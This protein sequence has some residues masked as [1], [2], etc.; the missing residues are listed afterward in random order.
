[1]ITDYASVPSSRHPQ[2]F[3]SFTIDFKNMHQVHP[4]F[5]CSYV[6][7]YSDPYLPMVYDYFDIMRFPPD[8]RDVLNVKGHTA[9]ISAKLLDDGTGMVVTE[10]LLPSYMWQNLAEMHEG[11]P[12]PKEKKIDMLGKARDY[13]ES[14]SKERQTTI[15]FPDGIIGTTDSIGADSGSTERQTDLEL[16]SN[17]FFCPVQSMTADKDGVILNY[18]GYWKIGIKGTTKKVSLTNHADIDSAAARMHKLKLTSKKGER[19]T[20]EMDEK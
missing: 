13:K 16:F 7:Q 17:M 3:D 19:K 1:M 14:P 5:G 12:F 10:P 2:G 15:Y 18:Y 8:G 11:D 20:D 6:K 9:C 4:G